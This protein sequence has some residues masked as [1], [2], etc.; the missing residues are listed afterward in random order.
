MGLGTGVVHN[1]Q[2]LRASAALLV[3]AMHAA[4]LGR[5]FGT[6]LL[7]YHFDHFGA[8]GVDVFFVIS[9]FIITRKAFLEGPV[10]GREFFLRRLRRV[11]PL[12]LVL[13]V[14]VLAFTFDPQ[15]A[16]YRSILSTFLMLPIGGIPPVITVGWTIGL[17]VVFYSVV[18]LVLLSASRR[19][20]ALVALI[21]YVAFLAS[22][23]IF[24]GP[25]LPTVGN[26]IYLEFLLGVVV[27][28]WGTT[29]V[30][31][32]LGPYVALA[33]AVLLLGTGFIDTR[34]AAFPNQILEGTHSMER[35]AIWG[36]PAFLIVL[37]A[38]ASKPWLQYDTALGRLV[39]YLGAASYSVYLAHWIVINNLLRPASL[40]LPPAMV[41]VAGL[42]LGLLGG[43]LVYHALER[44]LA[45]LFRGRDVQGIRAI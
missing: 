38:V 19:S 31:A 39:L 9:G 43:L 18:A 16:A 40:V 1:V 36:L 28:L 13:S 12:Y 37:G 2:A 44:P 25:I 42:S 35:V 21:I 20:A 22:G 7:P 6:S 17:E 30:S 15:T 34:M 24:R 4:E 23:F 11:A 29:F 8:P 14:L 32:R 27:A 3:L 10:T 33:G 26:P 45:S 41:I 5:P